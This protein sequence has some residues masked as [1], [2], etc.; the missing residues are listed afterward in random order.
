[1][2]IRILVFSEIAVCLKIL[3]KAVTKQKIHRPLRGE[4]FVRMFLVQGLLSVLEGT[5]FFPSLFF[6]SDLSS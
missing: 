3:F 4:Y 2:I 1:M 5:V 6:P